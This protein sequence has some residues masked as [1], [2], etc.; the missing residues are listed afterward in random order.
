ME[1]VQTF[2]MYLKDKEKLN[3]YF[4]IFKKKKDFYHTKKIPFF[5]FLTSDLE[6]QMS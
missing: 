4:Q 1:H 3:K 6:L 5:V 2:T